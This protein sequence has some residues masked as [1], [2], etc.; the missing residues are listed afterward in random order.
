MCSTDQREKE[1]KKGREEGE[2]T[3][4]REELMLARV[5]IIHSVTKE[6]K[7][8]RNRKDEGK[9]AGKKKRE[10]RHR[11]ARAYRCSRKCGRVRAAALAAVDAA[12][13]D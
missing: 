4:F 9:R 1:R 6:N 12:P 5:L 7:R 13:R 2:G 3:S 8:M 11:K 10:K